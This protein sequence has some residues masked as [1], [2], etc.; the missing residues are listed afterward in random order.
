MDPRNYIACSQRGLDVELCQPHCTGTALL[1]RFQ[2][3][4]ELDKQRVSYTLKCG[5]LY[6]M[7]TY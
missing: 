6:S 1:D 7:H 3:E 2:L 4:N 5:R